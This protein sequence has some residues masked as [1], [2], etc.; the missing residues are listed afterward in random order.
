MRLEGKIALVTG[1]ASGVGDQIC[2]SFVDEGSR[3]IVTDIDEDKGAQ[4]ARALTAEW[5]YLDVRDEDNW[6]RVMESALEL[7]GRVDVVVNNAGVIAAGAGQPQDPE[8]ASLE[9]WRAVHAINL[10]GTFL[11]CKHAIRAMRE[12]GRGSIINMSSRAG[13]AGVPGAAAYASSKAAIR[14]HTKSVALYCASQGLDIRCNSI[15]P[16]SVLTPIWNAALGEGAERERKAKAFASAIP[17][18]RFAAVEEVSPLA[19]LL[20]SDESSYI[21]GAE[22]VVDG[23][24]SAG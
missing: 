3:V 13:L 11:G 5:L 8:H 24:V 20:A 1:G 21:T 22:F 9:S 2:R 14:N 12:T 16:G 15:H 6:F 7:F 4:L 18:R 19:V 10:D 17:L 23:G